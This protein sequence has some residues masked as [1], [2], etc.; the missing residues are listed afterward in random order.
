MKDWR[1]AFCGQNPG[2]TS[3]DNYV[4]RHGVPGKVLILDGVFYDGHHRYAAAVANGI[5]Q[6]PTEDPVDEHGRWIPTPGVRPLPNQ[7]P[8]QQHGTGGQ[9]L[10]W[11]KKDGLVL[12]QLTASSG[13]GRI[14]AHVGGMDP[15]AGC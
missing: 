2:P 3:L 14:D 13:A 4:A 1:W 6:L 7:R 12:A 11:G 15:E 5:D 9:D 10:R 8:E